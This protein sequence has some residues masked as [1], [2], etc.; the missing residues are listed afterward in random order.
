[1]RNTDECMLSSFLFS[2]VLISGCRHFGR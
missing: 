2:H 1:M